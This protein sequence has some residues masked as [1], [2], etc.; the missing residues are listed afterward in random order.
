[1]TVS[2]S[3]PLLCDVIAAPTMAEL[4]ARRSRRT[5][6][7]GSQTRSRFAMPR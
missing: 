1:V 5:A 2:D 6:A 3:Q 7:V 4:R